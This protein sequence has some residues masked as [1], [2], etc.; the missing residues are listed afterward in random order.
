MEKKLVLC[1]RKIRRMCQITM[2]NLVY[3]IRRVNNQEPELKET[4]QQ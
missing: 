3:I 2:V 4:N 1:F